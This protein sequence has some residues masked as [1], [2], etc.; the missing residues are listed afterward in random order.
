MRSFFVANV[1]F[2]LNDRI[3]LPQSVHHHLVRVLRLAPG[4][5]FRLFDGCGQ[6][7][8][9]VLQDDGRAWLRQLHDSLPAPCRIRLIQGIPKGDKTELILQKGTEL[10]VSEFHLVTMERSVVRFKRESRQQLRWEKIIQEATRQ[11]GQYHLP[12]LQ[13]SDSLPTALAGDDADLK[14][15]LW[16]QSDAPLADVLGDKKYQRI[17]VIV[18]PEGGITEAEAAVAVSSGYQPVS[19]GPRILR[20]ET[21]GLAI[22][23]VLQYLYGDLS[24]S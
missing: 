19:L 22:I 16:E 1:G 18:G 13:C 2:R 4:A 11:S 10:G 3:T 9:A 23:A 12:Q 14:L 6:V 17:S 7:A 5:E 8:D 15:L 20:T 21:A 24:G